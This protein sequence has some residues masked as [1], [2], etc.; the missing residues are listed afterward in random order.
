MWPTRKA[1]ASTSEWPHTFSS[2]VPACY[3][4]SPAP[5]TALTST[6]RFSPCHNY[7]ISELLLVWI[8]PHEILL[9]LLFFKIVSRQPLALSWVDTFFPV[10]YTLLFSQTVLCIHTLLT[11]QCGPTEGYLPWMQSIQ[12]EKF[13]CV[14]VVW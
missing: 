2:S 6:V 11:T 13:A 10:I 8:S 1:H 12:H 5:S 7:K 14:V 3:L 9:I 4:R